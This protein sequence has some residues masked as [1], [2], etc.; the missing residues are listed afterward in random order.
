MKHVSISRLLLFVFSVLFCATGVGFVVDAQAAGIGCGVGGAAANPANPQGI[1]CGA[2]PTPAQLNDPA[3]SPNANKGLGA[4][5]D[6]NFMNQIYAKAFIEAEREM[7]ITNSTIT[8]PDSV[9]EYSCFDYLAARVATIAG[10]VFSERPWIMNVNTSPNMVPLNVSL[11]NT[12]LDRSI[13]QLVLASL[14]A[15]GDKNFP[16]DFLAGAAAGD[17]H[18]FSLTVAGA[19]GVC[20]HMFNMHF[21]AKCGDFGLSVPFMTFENYFS[22]PALLNTDPRTNPKV[23]PA[24]SAL[25]LTRS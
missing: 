8:K 1:P 23:C 5:C 21:L 19:A 14:D 22:V 20:D 4:A 17:N 18:D 25:A 7:V 15:Y 13:E 12:H 10:P 6:A 9:L 24:A 11:G 3:L 16:Y 2:P